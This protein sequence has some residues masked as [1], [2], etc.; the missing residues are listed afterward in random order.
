VAGDQGADCGVS[1]DKPVLTLIAAVARNGVIGAGNRL[2]WRLPSDLRRF[3]ALT[4]GKPLVMG[5]KTFAAIGKPLPGRETIV[6]TRDAA[7]AAPGVLVAHDLR[8]AL[9]LASERAAAMGTPEAIIA[10]GGEIYA[11]TIAQADRLA[12]T[13][14][15]LA[16]EGDARFPWIDPALWREARR[17]APPRG[18]GDEADFAFVDYTRQQ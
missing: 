4:L 14:V 13:E 12:I 9:A 15:A 6:V 1:K 2:I 16:P 3:K 10:G 7:F 8:T 11:A 18:A 5:R 17:E